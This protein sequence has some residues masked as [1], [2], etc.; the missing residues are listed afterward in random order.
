MRERRP[1]AES[2]SVYARRLTDIRAVSAFVLWDSL[3]TTVGAPL[4][5][6]WP[7]QLTR[8][9]VALEWDAPAGSTAAGPSGLP[10]R[11]AVHRPRTP[12]RC[13][14]HRLPR[15]RPAAA[16]VASLPQTASL[17]G[18]GEADRC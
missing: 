9:G 18:R 15:D 16:E 3:A 13:E 7:E 4:G 17:P 6:W 10:R 8:D 5:A 11:R 2:L 1:D 12:H 14:R